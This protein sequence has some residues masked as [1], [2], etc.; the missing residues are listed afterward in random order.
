MLRALRLAGRVGACTDAIAAAG[1]SL[2]ISALGSDWLGV[3]LIPTT[4]AETTLGAKKVG[5]TVNLEGDVVGKYLAKNMASGWAYRREACCR[6]VRIAFFHSPSRCRFS[7]LRRP[8]AGTNYI[9]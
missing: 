1:V 5:D 7:S 2:T 4:A 9:W 6:G 8:G 3:D